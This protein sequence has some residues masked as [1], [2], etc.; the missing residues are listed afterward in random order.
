ML[1]AGTG[2]CTACTKSRYCHA[3]KRN[4]NATVEKIRYKSAEYQAATV[5][6]VWESWK[7]AE[8]V[9]E[10]DAALGMRSPVWVGSPFRGIVSISQQCSI[11]T[12]H[13]V[14]WMHEALKLGFSVFFVDIDVYMRANPL[15]WLV[16]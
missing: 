2:P 15:P 3:D 14:V 8:D 13:Q 9:S 4:Q 12:P 5:Q 11:V 7:R 1:T 10:V 16:R 6:K